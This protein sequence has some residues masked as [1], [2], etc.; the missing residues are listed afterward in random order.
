MIGLLLSLLL[1]L[2]SLFLSSSQSL[3][4]KISLLS[5]QP[6]QLYRTSTVPLSVSLSSPLGPTRVLCATITWSHG[7]QTFCKD[8]LDAW[9]LSGL[10]DGAYHLQ[11]E[12]RSAPS[13]DQDGWTKEEDLIIEAKAD[14]RFAVEAGEVK[15][16]ITITWPSDGAT[17]SAS[18]GDPIEVSFDSVGVV[19][20]VCHEDVC[21]PA[22]SGTITVPVSEGA[23]EVQLRGGNLRSQVSMFTVIPPPISDV[24]L[25]KCYGMCESS[26]PNVAVITAR[27][28]DR[29]REAETMIKSLLLHSDRP[30]H[31]HIIADSGG[32]SHFTFL[33][34][35]P[36]AVTYYDFHSTCSKPVRNFLDAYGFPQSPHYS[37]AAGYCRLFLP[38]IIPNPFVAIETDQLFLSSYL[39]I[40]DIVSASSALVAAPE[41]YVSWAS[42]RPRST[43][44]EYIL[45]TADKGSKWNGNGYIGGIM[46]FDIPASL[47]W[48]SIWTTAFD[49]YLSTAPKDWIPRLNDQD[50]FN[51][52]FTTSPE[53][54][55][56]LPCAFNL[57]YHSYMNH[58]R[59]CPS[60]LSCDESVGAG[61][62]LCDETPAVLHFMAGTYRGGDWGYYGGFWRAYEGLEWDVIV[63]SMGGQ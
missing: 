50:V 53:L 42:G 63:H 43:G 6:N 37:G 32:L 12:V 44:P 51:A 55:T 11:L 9:E 8:K 49:A 62:F 57:Q 1:L 2:L 54:A 39:P 46:A 31:L 17:V 48:S 3:P 25:Q 47:S 23:N 29:Y 60:G 58:R 22:E 15:D 35:L 40:L 28:V 38:G 56:P 30:P 41:M 13:V 52:V 61:M 18:H 20:S 16:R 7:S 59:L 10:E 45:H 21:V 19:G 24:E 5:P 14:I 4:T 33:R 27:T 36:L 34:G 26:L